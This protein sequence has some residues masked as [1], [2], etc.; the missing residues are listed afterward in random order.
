MPPQLSVDGELI[1]FNG[2]KPGQYGVDI[3]TNERIILFWKPLL[4]KENSYA[5]TI[6]L[7]EELED[8]IT[9]YYVLDR[10]EEKCYRFDRT[11]YH[12]ANIIHMNNQSQYVPDVAENS[13]VWD[14]DEIIITLS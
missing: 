3:N 13:G 9:T 2:R 11:T 1:R 5:M 8:D 14:P 10:D 6:D 12:K 4:R 7:F